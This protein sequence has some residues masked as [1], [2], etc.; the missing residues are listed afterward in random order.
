MNDPRSHTP[1]VVATTLVVLFLA[2]NVG[3]YFG[4][5]KNVLYEG[6]VTL[7]YYEVPYVANLFAPLGFIEAT[8]T[9]K[10]ILVADK[11]KNKYYFRGL[12]RSK[13]QLDDSE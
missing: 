11:W 10:T 3:C 4:L 5:D 8:L 1:W 7:R 13:P 9:G 12:G 2:V 6:H